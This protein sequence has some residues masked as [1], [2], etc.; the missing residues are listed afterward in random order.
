MHCKMQE[1]INRYKYNKNKNELLSGYSGEIEAISR[2]GQ[3]RKYGCSGMS[4][5]VPVP[6]PDLRTIKKGG[7][8]LNHI[9]DYHQIIH[10]RQH[11]LN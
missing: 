4:F 8:Y 5:A 9:I 3:F 7:Q 11:K 10:V 1:I 2:I 6:T